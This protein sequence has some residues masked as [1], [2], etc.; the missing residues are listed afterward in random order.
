MREY[1]ALGAPA[2][3][4][5]VSGRI[6]ESISSGIWSLRVFCQR[7]GDARIPVLAQIHFLCFRLNDTRNEP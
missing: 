5:L 2:E 1:P 6:A 7:P 4:C 3:A